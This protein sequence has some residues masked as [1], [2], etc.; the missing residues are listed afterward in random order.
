MH[1]DLKSANILL[2][3]DGEAKLSDFG[4]SSSKV[5]FLHLE[6]TEKHGFLNLIIIQ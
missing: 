3:S 1:R 4:V 5:F 6:S 2:N